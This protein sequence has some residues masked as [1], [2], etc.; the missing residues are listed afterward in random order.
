MVQS[1]S[2]SETPCVSSC[3]LSDWLAT[4]PW[5]LRAKQEQHEMPYGSAFQRWL[6]VVDRFRTRT[7]FLIADIAEDLT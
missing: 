3:A 1:P 4:L 7:G 6:G 5:V 2:Q